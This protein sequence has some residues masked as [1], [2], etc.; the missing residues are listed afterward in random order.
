MYRSPGT[1]GL[2][3]SGPRTV[4]STVAPPDGP[5]GTWAT[6]VVAE[7]TVNDAGADPNRTEVAPEKSDPLTVT[8]PPPDVGPR[9]GTTDSIRG[10]T[11]V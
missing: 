11:K 7:L 10:D 6:S 5:G 1:R 8:S 2:T 4:T 3:P 9:S